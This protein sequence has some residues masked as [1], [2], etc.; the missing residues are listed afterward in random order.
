[1][2]QTHLSLQPSE[3]AIVTAAATIYAAYLAA[4]RVEDGQESVW[5]ERS[6]KAAIR[7][8]KITDELVR[9]WAQNNRL[10]WEVRHGE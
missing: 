7:I 8:A 9:D 1:M 4:G 10:R 3:Q 6:I 5:M 2:K